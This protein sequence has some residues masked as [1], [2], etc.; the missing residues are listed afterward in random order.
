LA[1]LPA[2]AARKHINRL[3]AWAVEAGSPMQSAAIWSLGFAGGHDA[4]KALETVIARESQDA[5]SRA[6]AVIA[7]A[8]ASVHEVGFA[9][10][11]KNAAAPDLR[12]A[13]R[14][15]LGKSREGETTT[16]PASTGGWQKA[17]ATGG[18]GR[19]GRRMFFSPQ[20]ACAKCHV[21]EGR[22]AIVGPDLSAVG[23]GT[24]RARLVESIVEPSREVAIDFQG[25]EIETKSGESFTGMQAKPKPDGEVSMLG[26]DGRKIEVEGKDIASFRMLKTSLMPDGLIEAMSVEDFRDLLAY[27]EALK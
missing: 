24:S 21:A 13:A 10:P 22:G 11:W 4:A 6:D 8:M 25:Y 14:L 18:D 5:E 7:R 15:V 3:S 16:R 23:R 17:V 9:E 26:F 2:E 27:L 20:L 19:R 12:H 1:L